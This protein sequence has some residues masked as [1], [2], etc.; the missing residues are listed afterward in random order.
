MPRTN[1]INGMPVE[2]YKDAG[3]AIRDAMANHKEVAEVNLAHYA[4]RAA[5]RA[6]KHKDPLAIARNVRDAAAVYR[7]VFPP[8]QGGEMVEGAILVGAALVRDNPVEMLATTEVSE[9]EDGRSEMGG[10]RSEIEDRSSEIGDREKPPSSI[11]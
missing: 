3:D 8:E 4:A 1:G 5:T 11:S 10:G 9:I 6:A 2:A 7:T